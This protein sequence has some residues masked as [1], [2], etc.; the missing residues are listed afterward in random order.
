MKPKLIFS[1]FDGTL[2]LED[3]LTAQFFDILSLLDY[4]EIPLVIVTGRSKSWAHF[5]LSHIHALT[6]VITEGGGV[7]SKVEVI[8]K[9]RVLSDHL[10]IDKEH[11]QRLIEVTEKLLKNF[12]KLRLSVD[13]FGRQTDRAIE[14]GDL[15]DDEKMYEEVKSF[16]DSEDVHYS[17]SNVH[18]N[19][20][21]GPISKMAAIDH[22]LLNKQLNEKDVMFFG[23]NL[24]DQS[25]FAGITN[26]VGVSNIDLVL[27]KMEN[28]PKTILKGED[29]IGPMGVYSH[30]SELLK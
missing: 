22:V 30:L 10:L 23:D 7:L 27:D 2:T 19:Y 8:N 17:T 28:K 12:K 4:H 11:P 26:S 29:N 1:D 21:C 24:N 20:W 15:L 13:S 9:R 18:L 6:E 5:L 14:L 3:E 25:A 16:L